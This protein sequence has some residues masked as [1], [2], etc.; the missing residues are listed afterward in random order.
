MDATIISYPD[1]AV[2]NLLSLA[3]NRS[4]YMLPFAGRFR[5][6]DF[7]IGNA[8]EVDA[9]TII[10]S[11]I[12]DD[13]AEYVKLHAVDEARLKVVVDDYNSIDFCYS[14][15]RDSGS[16][17]FIIYNGDNPGII[18]FENLL[19]QFI[20]L[21]KP[22]AL[23]KM[24]FEERARMAHRILVTTKKALL[25]A[26]KQALKRGHSAPNIFEMIINLMVNEGTAK[27]QFPCMYWP[28]HTIVDY[29]NYNFHVIDNPEYS[30]LVFNGRIRSKIQLYRHSMLGLH[31]RVHQSFLS[32]SSYV[33]GEVHNSILFPGV[34]I[35]EGA[36]VRNSIILPYNK[37]GSKARITQT[38]VD[39]RTVSPFD[40]SLLTI[41]NGCKIGTA[42]DGMK[43]SDYPKV[44]YNSITLIGK[45]CTIPG[46]IAVGGACYISQNRQ[47]AD[48]AKR[49]YI[50]N[51][52]SV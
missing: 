49:K 50:Y 13:L 32:D 22:S 6:V 8:K 35:A 45:N 41:G 30:K 42:E 25:D 1:S 24:H 19:E 17:Y 27:S 33:N 23:F 34:E 21:K 11:N 14:L 7:I 9:Q 31:A 5:V 46:S 18:H 51:G 52:T 47:E 43:N 39:E 20:K 37:I 12:N 38:I 10:Y 3:Q 4:K 29:Y 36:V 48:F 16:A 40:E 44:L 28:L 2:V 15:I 26:M